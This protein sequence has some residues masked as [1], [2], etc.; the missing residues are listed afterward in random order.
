MVPSGR[1]SN[2]SGC[3]LIQ[4]WSGEH[5]MAKSSAISR[6]C[7]CAASTQAA[8]V[9]E[10]A[11]LGVD[12]VVAAFVAADRVRAADIVG[13]PL[14][15]VVLALA[16]FSPDRVDGREIKNIEAHVANGRQAA[17]HVVEGAVTVRAIRRRAREQLV[18]GGELRLRSL[19]LE[20]Q[21]RLVPVQEGSLFSAE[22]DLEQIT[23]REECLRRIRP[24]CRSTNSAP[25]R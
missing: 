8:K 18:P 6:P 10:R 24:M 12:R 20:H 3:S 2:H 14:Q 5:W 17:D 19:D 25:R 21:R 11:E 23:C 9:V 16:I 15:A 4:G 22:H 7:A 13:S 1:Q